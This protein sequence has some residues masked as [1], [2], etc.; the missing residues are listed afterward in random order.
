MLIAR[1]VRASA[2]HGYAAAAAVRPPRYHETH[3]RGGPSDE[4]RQAAE[5]EDVGES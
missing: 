1:P 5:R 4:E 3:Y 2:I